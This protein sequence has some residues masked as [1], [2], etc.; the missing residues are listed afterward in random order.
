MRPPKHANGDQRTGGGLRSAARSDYALVALLSAAAVAAIALVVEFRTVGTALFAD[1]GWD[2]HLYREMAHRAPLDFQIAP[3]SWRVL[4][5]MLARIVPGPAET[6]FLTVTTAALV[7]AG[8]ALYWLV[9]STGASRWASFAAV[10]L[11]YALGWATRYQLSDFWVP[12]ATAFLFTVVA[13]GMVVRKWWVPAAAVMAVGVLA[14]ESVV[15]AGVLA[16]SWHARGWR[17]W[18]AARTAALVVI[19]AL[20]VLLLI[21]VLV[22]SENGNADYIA[23]MPPEIS[24]F[25]ELFPEYSYSQRYED[26]FVN[27]RWAHRQWDDFDRYLADPFG[28]PLLVLAAAGVAATPSRALRLLPFVLLVY[29]QLLFATDT[30]RLL[31]LAAPALAIL[32]AGGMDWLGVRLRVPVWTFAAGA[33]AVFALSLAEGAEFGTALLWQTALVAVLLG[34]AAAWRLVRP[35]SRPPQQSLQPP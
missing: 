35:P 21:R 30:Q 19:P 32:A 7:A 29:S 12:D 20:V 11:Y 5:P 33:G 25:P 1:P 31:V 9:R 17:D 34:A 28:I 14:K 23:E 27:E 2:R 3:Y 10:P 16:L 6:G 4:V 8:P 24:R 15:F 26:I 22:P 18:P 13:A